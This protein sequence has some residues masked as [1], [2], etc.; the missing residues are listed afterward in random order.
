MLPKQ[1]HTNYALNNYCFEQEFRSKNRGGGVCLYIHHTL[2]YKLRDD[3][4]L[5][6]KKKSAKKMDKEINSVFV[7]IDKHSTSTKRNIIVG[8]IYR[9][10]S[11][12]MSEFNDLLY[13]L[14]D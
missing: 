7:E 12:S 14:L 10:P 6:H 8:C 4:K 13:D 5:V 1:H 11:S 2:T 9:P 3:L